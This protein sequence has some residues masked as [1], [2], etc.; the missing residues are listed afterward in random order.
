MRTAYKVIG[1]PGARER[2]S[3]DTYNVEC[4]KF[5]SKSKN[6]Y[7]NLDK[8]YKVVPGGRKE[9]GTSSGCAAKSFVDLNE[10][11]FRCAQSS[12]ALQ[13]GHEREKF[14]QGAG[15]THG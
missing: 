2:N 4:Q 6:S 10:L 7:R 13:S 14:C 1:S 12:I 9:F 15:I 11:R 3:L 5:C 8:E